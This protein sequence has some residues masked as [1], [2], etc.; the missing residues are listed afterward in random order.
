[1]AEAIEQYLASEERPTRLRLAR[2][3]LGVRL[4]QMG[5]GLGYSASH[6]SLVERGILRRPELEQRMRDWLEAHAAHLKAAR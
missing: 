1:M 6:L 5:H 4:W 3:R 2:L